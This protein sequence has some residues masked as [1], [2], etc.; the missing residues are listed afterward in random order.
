[1]H[2]YGYYVM[3]IYFETI[4]VLILFFCK[5]VKAFRSTM[6]ESNGVFMYV[7]IHFEDH[8]LFKM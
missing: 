6:V 7:F 2:H 8:E 3:A 5:I 4:N 1:M